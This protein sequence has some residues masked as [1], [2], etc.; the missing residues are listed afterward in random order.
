LLVTFERQFFYLSMGKG[1]FF[2]ELEP[3]QG[4]K[5]LWGRGGPLFSLPPPQDFFRLYP[6]LSFI[7]IKNTNFIEYKILYEMTR[8]PS[9][10]FSLS[11]SSKDS[12][13]EPRVFS[14]IVLNAC[15]GVCDE[16]EKNNRYF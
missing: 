5:L 7:R 15:L 4:R 3:D 12:N 10:V 2:V 6:Y 9:L 8:N 11:L 16:S 13:P 14:S 1:D